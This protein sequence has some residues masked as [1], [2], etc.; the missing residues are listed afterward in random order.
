MLVDTIKRPWC[1]MAF[2][3]GMRQWSQRAGGGA[4]VPAGISTIGSYQGAVG[5]ATSYGTEAV[6][7][8]TNASASYIA[9]GVTGR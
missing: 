2:L 9:D 7:C 8:R 1:R 5:E 3:Y 6:L 4:V